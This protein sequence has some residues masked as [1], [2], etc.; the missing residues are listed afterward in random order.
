MFRN[1]TLL[2]FGLFLAGCNASQTSSPAVASIG[3]GT[4]AQ[5]SPAQVAA[6]NAWLACLDRSSRSQSRLGRAAAA[7]FAFSACQ[8][9][10][11]TLVARLSQ[12]PTLTPA[13]ARAGLQRVKADWKRDH[14]KGG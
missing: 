5:P 3:P 10:E 1:V 2:A 12:D 4:M 14:L 8:T 6:R 9:E 13:S 7:D 11:D